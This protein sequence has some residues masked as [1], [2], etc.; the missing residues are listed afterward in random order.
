MENLAGVI[1]FTADYMA[2]E[3]VQYFDLCLCDAHMR[4]HILQEKPYIPVA[5][6]VSLKAL[7]EFILDRWRMKA[8][9]VMISIVTGVFQFKHWPDDYTIAFQSGL[10]KVS[11]ISACGI[12]VP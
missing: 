10:T 6:D 4:C 9:D 11:E 12:F 5:A 7:S 8:P 2:S 3:E 1:K